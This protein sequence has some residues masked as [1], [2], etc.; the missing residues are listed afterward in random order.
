MGRTPHLTERLDCIETLLLMDWIDRAPPEPLDAW[1][2]Q[3][4]VEVDQPRRPLNLLM[5]GRGGREFLLQKFDALPDDAPLRRTIAGLLANEVR[6]VHKIGDYRFFSPTKC[7]KIASRI[8][9][10]P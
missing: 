6:A 9:M 8:P 10:E 4:V 5:L 7:E 1:F 3:R 2:Q